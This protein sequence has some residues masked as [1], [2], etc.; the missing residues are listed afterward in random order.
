[1]LLN[2]VM[3]N[4]TYLLEYLMIFLVFLL[5]TDEKDTQNSCRYFVIEES[6]FQ[7][8]Y[9]WYNKFERNYS[10]KKVTLWGIHPPSFPQDCKV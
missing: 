6:I 9:L 8:V 4:R 7:I 3:K 1:M 10:G 5:K 2:T